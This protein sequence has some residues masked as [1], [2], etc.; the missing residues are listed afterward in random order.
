MWFDSACYVLRMAREREQGA[1]L[2]ARFPNRVLIDGRM[3]APVPDEQHGSASTYNNHGCRC[4]PCERANTLARWPGTPERVQLSAA[5]R[6]QLRMAQAR[7]AGLRHA[8]AAGP[9]RAGAIASAKKARN[10]LV[11][12]LDDK[13][14]HGYGLGKQ[15][16]EALGLSRYMVDRILRGK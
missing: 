6:A 5:E 15:L 12:E 3:V 4:R 7:Y 8:K 9:D 11:L 16:A 1:D 13:H 2:A 14:G 10:A